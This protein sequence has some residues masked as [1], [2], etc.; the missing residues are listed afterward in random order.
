M[1]FHILKREDFCARAG[2]P[3]VNDTMRQDKKIRGSASSHRDI[4]LGRYGSVAIMISREFC[5]IVK[6]VLRFWCEKIIK[7]STCTNQC[8]K[9][10]LS[11]NY[12]FTDDAIS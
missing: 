6:N 4:D 10:F 8:K 1:E 3:D 9:S 12:S 11:Y 5:V 2:L 7:K